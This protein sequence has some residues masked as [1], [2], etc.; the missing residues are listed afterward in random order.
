M[1]LKDDRKYSFVVTHTTRSQI[2]I[3]RFEISKRLAKGVLGVSI[4]S[5]SCALFAVYNY[6][7][8]NQNLVANNSRP[9]ITDETQQQELKNLLA[10]M[11]SEEQL[12]AKSDSD[13]TVFAK[14]G[15]PETPQFPETAEN[16]NNFQNEN[17]KSAF[18]SPKING[19]SE[20]NTP[21]I[22]PRIGKI[23]NEFGWRRNPF[24]GRSYEN[25]PGI[26]IDGERGDQ[27][28][29]PANGVVLKTGWSGGYGNMLEIDHGNGLTTRYGHLSKIEVEVG[30]EITRGQE[31]ALIGTTG[32]ST[33]PHLHY[34]VRIDNQSVNPRSYLPPVPSSETLQ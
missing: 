18:E 9:E 11:R 8:V 21:N 28:I 15:G 29:A 6:T 5:L 20:E 32:R 3:R 16:S 26:D 7:S 24:G 23:N 22:W 14:S 4:V 1:N 12:P 31:I 27:V 25:H 13:Q 30:Q 33:G 10:Q 19:L 2:Y 34:E 17:I